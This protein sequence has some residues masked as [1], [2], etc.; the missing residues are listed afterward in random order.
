MYSGHAGGHCCKGT[1][2]KTPRSPVHIG[3]II[4]SRGPL[5]T[6]RVGI[7]SDLVL[8]DL[9]SILVR[10]SVMNPVMP[11][12]KICTHIYARTLSNDTH[13]C[14]RTLSNEAIHPFAFGQLVP[15]SFR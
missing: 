11:L 9:H 6:A 12:R 10:A 7:E 14:A 8:D 13:I 3:K 2:I 1:G 4:I 5:R 15:N